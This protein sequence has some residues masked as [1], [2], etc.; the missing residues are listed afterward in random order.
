MTLLRDLTLADLEGGLA[1]VRDGH[2]GKRSSGASFCSPTAASN[3]LSTVRQ[4][5][6]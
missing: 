6:S 1:I 5:T 4:P 2:E 3:P